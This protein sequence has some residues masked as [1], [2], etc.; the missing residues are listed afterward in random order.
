MALNRNSVG[1]SGGF[2]TNARFSSKSGTG[3]FGVI[4]GSEEAFVQISSAISERDPQR[5]KAPRLPAIR[6][7]QET[8][9]TGKRGHHGKGLFAGGISRL[10]KISNFSRK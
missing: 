4:L 2:R 1:I 3:W 5:L 8:I 9:A 6:I 7:W 10:S